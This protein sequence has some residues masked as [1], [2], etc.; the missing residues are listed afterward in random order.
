M[1][2]IINFLGYLEVY[3]FPDQTCIHSRLGGYRPL[4]DHIREYTKDH[5]RLL[6][7][8]DQRYTTDY[9]DDDLFSKS[10][11]RPD[12]SRS[13]KKNDR[14]QNCRRQQ[15]KRGKAKEDV[16]KSF[17]LGKVRT[18]SHQGSIV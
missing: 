4:E 18:L 15:S 12:S 13:R 7:M 16:S 2:R 1:N 10:F 11:F 6:N 5:S 17:T 14:G 9:Q 8:V 3:V